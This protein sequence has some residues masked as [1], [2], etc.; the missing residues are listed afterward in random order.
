ME[1]SKTE[2]YIHTYT[3]D[4]MGFRLFWLHL[5]QATSKSVVIDKE[6]SFSVRETLEL[7]VFRKKRKVEK[8]SY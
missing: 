2:E 6:G 8:D 1:S 4:I 7:A 5:L 3:A